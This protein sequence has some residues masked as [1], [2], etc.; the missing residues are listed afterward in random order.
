MT[1]LK[2][3][4]NLTVQQLVLQVFSN[5]FNELIFDYT[6]QQ[7]FIYNEFNELLIIENHW[8]PVAFSTEC[9]CNISNDKISASST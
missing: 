2:I 5:N 6:L 8:I 3:L 4:S 7:Y 1:F 9:L